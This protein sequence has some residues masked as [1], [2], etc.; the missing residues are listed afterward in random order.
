MLP[1]SFGMSPGSGVKLVH[2]DSVVN[3]DNEQPCTRGR[4]SALI[5]GCVDA[6]GRNLQ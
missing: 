3:D 6:E 4:L 5:V 1:N 2:S